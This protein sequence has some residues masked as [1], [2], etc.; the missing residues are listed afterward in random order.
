M[1]LSP[2]LKMFGGCVNHELNM[3]EDYG[4]LISFD[5]MYE[6]KKARHLDSYLNEKMGIIK[7]K[8]PQFFE[9]MGDNLRVMILQRRERIQA[10]KAEKLQK[11][12]AKKK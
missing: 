1:G 9:D 12:M 2:T 8:F 10:R 6:E 3:I 4:I 5:D 11:R 7:N